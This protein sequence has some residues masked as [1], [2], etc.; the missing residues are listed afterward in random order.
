M[1]YD[2]KA[3][4]EM[5]FNIDIELNNSEISYLRSKFILNR[6]SVINNIL[7]TDESVTKVVD[8]LIDKSIL[9][10][11]YMYNITLTSIGD[12]ILDKIDRDKKIRSLLNE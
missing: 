12:K 7:N 3:K 1:A 11:D 4:K 8:S 10:A 5:I 2:N 6:K 9:S